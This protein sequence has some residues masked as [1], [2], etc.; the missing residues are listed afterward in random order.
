MKTKLELTN[1]LA[2]MA[3]QL[4]KRAL[5]T[6]AFFASIYVAFTKFFSFYTFG[7]KIYERNKILSVVT[8]H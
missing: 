5:L 3:T 7:S 8:A 6:L 2:G 4:Y 1:H